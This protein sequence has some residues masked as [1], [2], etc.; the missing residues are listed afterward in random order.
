M[1]DAPTEVRRSVK[2][3]TF[4]KKFSDISP[5]IAMSASRAVSGRG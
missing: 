3:L 1:T 4:G 2:Q 5:K